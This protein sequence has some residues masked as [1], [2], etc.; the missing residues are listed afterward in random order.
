LPLYTEGKELLAK[1]KEK[2]AQIQAREEAEKEKNVEKKLAIIEKIKQLIENPSQEDFN[3]TYQ[4]FKSL[5]QQWNDIKLIPQAKAN[6]LWKSYQLYV[7]RFYDLV[8]IN[9]EFREYDF[10][11]NLEL[12]TEL[13]EAAERLDEEPDVISAF[14]QCKICISSGVKSAQYLARIVK[15][16]GIGSKKHPT[17]STK[18]IRRISKRLNCKK[19]KISRKNRH[20]A[21]NWN[22][23]TIRR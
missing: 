23:L 17:K 15:K 4:E 12:K 3:K 10:K 11:K 16:S 2:R 14:H 19:M 21:N 22:R 1:I 6:D 18:N 8:R 13:C 20:L 9:N 7:E 5:Q